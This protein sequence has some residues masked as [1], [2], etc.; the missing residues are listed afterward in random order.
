MNLTVST[1]L[2]ITFEQIEKLPDSRFTK[3]KI[4]LCHT[5][6]N[7]NNSYF[8]KSVIEEAIPS[9]ANIPILGFIQVDNLNEADFKGHEQR[10]MIDENGVTVEYLGRAYGV[11]PEDNR[12]YF[13]NKLCDDNVTREF[14]VVEGVLWNKFKDATEIIINNDSRPQSMELTPSSIEGNFKKDGVFY[15]SKF[16]FEGACILGSNIT[17]AMRGS[18][19][20]NVDFSLN[21][22][23]L[24]S[25]LNEFNTTYSELNQ[26]SKEDD[27]KYKGG[28]NLNEKLELFKKFPTLKDEDIAEL[29]ANIEQYSLEELESNLNQIVK[30][31]TDSNTFSLTAQQ[32]QQEIRGALTLERV[33]DKWNDSV[34]AYWYIDHDDTRVYAED[35]QDGYLPVGLNYTKSGDSVVIDFESKKRIKWVPQDLEEGIETAVSFVSID[36]SA[37]ELEI[38]KKTVEQDFFTKL[39]AIN[40][41][42]DELKPQFE[43]TK[44]QNEKLQAEVS[45]YSSNVDN[46]KL[47]VQIN[48]LSAYKLAREKQ[49]KLDVIKNF[50]DLTDDEKKPFQDEVDKYAI[51]ELEDKLFS[52]VG[53]KGLSSFSANR[54]S[55]EYLTTSLANFEAQT[56]SNEPTWASLV[57]DFKNKS[58]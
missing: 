47:K 8:E 14:L 3:V 40:T 41:E 26:P 28:V 50:K 19:I 34:R 16:Q 21:S 17:P 35:T 38:T 56:K 9:L 20:E 23:S 46:E 44:A 11:I 48:E 12:A 29:K 25:M 5:G 39:E 32:L 31:Q 49:D 36:R 4:Y 1:S 22:A 10:L 53:R 45:E 24:Q 33:I 54:G 51:E 57:E 52:F 30:S 37:A 6:K 13:E 43:A 18:V 42:L 2:P 55:K 27:N 58:N 15:F 7:L